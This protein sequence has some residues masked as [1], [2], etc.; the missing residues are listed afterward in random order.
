M[1]AVGFAPPASEDPELD[2]LREV[3]ERLNFAI[4]GIKEAQASLSKLNLGQTR[5]RLNNAQW[6]AREAKKILTEIGAAKKTRTTV[7]QRNRR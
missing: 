3:C 6:Q 5:E 1:S 7:K 4:R 2:R